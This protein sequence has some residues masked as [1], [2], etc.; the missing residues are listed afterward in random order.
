MKAKILIIGGGASGLSLAKLLADQ[1]E[2]FLVL[3]EPKNRY[4]ANHSLSSVGRSKKSTV[5]TVHECA[6]GTKYW[7][8]GLVEM[9]HQDFEHEYSFGS[10]GVFKNIE[11]YYHDAWAFFN[12]DRQE[13][14]TKDGHDSLVIQDK[15]L[16]FSDVVP[17]DRI[18][19]GSIKSVNAEGGQ[20]RSISFLDEY[21]ENREIQIE[22][23]VISAGTIGTILALYRYNIL[24]RS[25]LESMSTGIYTHPK[26]SLHGAVNKIEQTAPLISV[27]KYKLFFQKILMKSGERSHSLRFEPKALSALEWIDNALS[28]VKLSKSIITFLNIIAKNCYLFILRTTLL[29]RFGVLKVY[30]DT[31]KPNFKYSYDKKTQAI[32]LDFI[33]SSIELNGLQDDLGHLVPDLSRLTIDNVTTV[34]THFLGGLKLSSNGAAIVDSRGKLTTFNNIWINSGAILNGKGYANPIL[35]LVALSHVVNEQLVS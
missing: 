18:I 22:K 29:Q 34:H 21:S 8:G 1:G 13:I 33:P 14:S 5:R 32:L 16:N 12:I 31:P 24:S 30:L 26:L 28:T 23:L 2:D 10:E 25:V 4:N 35:T 19:V 9:N 7:G 11:P 6:G 17:T 20:V 15:A 27:T 3:T